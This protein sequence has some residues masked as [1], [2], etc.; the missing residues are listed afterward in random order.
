MQQ[1][2]SSFTA[3]VTNDAETI[4]SI[5]CHEVRGEEGEGDEEEEE[6]RRK[7]YKKH[8]YPRGNGRRNPQTRS[9]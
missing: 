4:T 1:L 9:L 7:K 8:I 3:N 5:K 6:G 2:V